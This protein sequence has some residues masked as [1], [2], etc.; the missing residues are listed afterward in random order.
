MV[1]LARMADRLESARLKL[2]HAREHREAF[3]RLGTEWGK[4]VFKTWPVTHDAE[5]DEFTLALETVPTPDPDFALILGD[6]VHNYRSSLD[7]LAFQLVK[8]PDRKPREKRAPDGEIAFPIAAC[9]QAYDPGPIQG[10]ADRAKDHIRAMQPFNPGWELLLVLKKLD[11][12]DKHRAVHL[13]SH[14]IAGVGF[15]NTEVVEKPW[16]IKPGTRIEDGAVLAR[17]KYRPDADRQTDIGP[18]VGMGIE[19]D[20]GIVDGAEVLGVLERIGWIVEDVINT[21]AR[22]VAP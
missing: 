15:L 13:V 3:S 11:D 1:R 5:N 12:R 6:A 8:H 20:G 14:T 2:G 10:A 4:E 16:L 19:F 9:E 18:F 7:H 21:L 17:W 22:Y